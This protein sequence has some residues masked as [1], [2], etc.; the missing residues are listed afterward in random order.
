LRSKTQDDFLNEEIN[1]IVATVAFGM[2]IDK[3]DIRF[4]IHY[5]IAKSIENYYQETGRAG[6]DG[7]EGNCI[8]YFNYKDINK[9]EKMLSDKTVTERERGM[10]LIDET[11]AYIETGECRR[12]FLLNYFGQDYKDNLCSEHKMCDNCRNPKEQ[13]DITQDMVLALETINVCE[14]AHYL[15]HIAK[16]LTGIKSDAIASYKHHLLPQFGAGKDKEEL[17][18]TSVLRNAIIQ[19]LIYREIEEYGT[20]KMNPK[21]YEYIEKPYKIK[22]ALNHDY[23]NESGVILASSNHSALD[24][25]LFQILKDIRKS[26]AKKQNLPPYVLIQDPS[27]EEMCLKYPITLEEFADITGITKAKVHKFGALFVK[28]IAKHVELN[29]IERPMDYT[30]RTVINK[31]SDKVKIIKSIDKKISLDILSDELQYT[32]EELVDE[33]ESIVMNGT[34][35]DIN[36]Y[37][38]DIMDGELLE[39]MFDWFKGNE[40]GDIEECYKAFV[41]DDLPKD[42]IQLVKLQ[43][44]SNYIK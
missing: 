32:F 44:I 2:G 21:G 29:Q 33:L 27:L 35:V 26:E 13:K 10:V 20:L 24:K 30:I 17:Y 43:F 36:Y 19:N 42:D 7:L 41:D 4:V 11:V 1:V 28:E 9:V 14:E 37:L 31:S 25:A 22:I 5:N 34:K 15:N 3:P 6:R 18:W 39:E 23:E 8:A 38:N 12:K 16:I 40:M